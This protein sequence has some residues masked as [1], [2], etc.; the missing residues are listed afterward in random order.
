VPA[1]GGGGG[2]IDTQVWRKHYAKV[3]PRRRKTDEPVEHVVAH[4]LRVAGER[5]TIATS[6][7]A[8]AD[9]A[10]ARF[11]LRVRHFGR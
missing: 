6:G 1:R 9:E 8:K 4:P 2:Y 11:D 3:T 5:R 7:R 10:V